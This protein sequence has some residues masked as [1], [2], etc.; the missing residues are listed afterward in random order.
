MHYFTRGP[1]LAIVEDDKAVARFVKDGWEEVTEDAFVEAWKARDA[2][3]F[4]RAVGEA[5]ED[6]RARIVG[7]L[8][9]KVYP[10][11]EPGL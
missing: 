9:G 10:K 7:A 4:S 2:A 5:G 8:P 6:T 1:A 3:N 11:K